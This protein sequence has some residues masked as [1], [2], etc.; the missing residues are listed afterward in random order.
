MLQGRVAVIT[1]GTGVLGRAVTRLFV[2][3]GARVAVPCRRAEDAQGLREELGDHAD[4]LL[5]GRVD[6]TNGA[7]LTRFVDGVG[8]GGAGAGPPGAH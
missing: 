7:E 3:E 5:A 1:G 4:A 2:A 8:G 6:V